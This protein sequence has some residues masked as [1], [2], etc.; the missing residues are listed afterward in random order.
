[1]SSVARQ[2]LALATRASLALGV[3]VWLGFSGCGKQTVLPVKEP[4]KC[5]LQV[6]TFSVIAS[7]QINP[8]ENGEPRPVQF[9]L[10]QLKNDV[11]FLNA[12]FDDVWKKDK[13]ILADDL[14]KVDE[15][16]A[17]PN[18]RT[19]VKFERDASAQYIVAAALF[20]TPKGRSWYTSYELP[21]PPSKGQCGVKGEDGGGPI[22]DPK[23]YAWIDRTKVEDGVEHAEDFPEGRVQSVQLPGGAPAAPAGA[24]GLPSMPGAPSLPGAPELPNAPSVPEVKA[25]EVP[26]PSLP[27]GMP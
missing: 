23:F 13:E 24:P 17:Y 10:Y 2:R 5:D 1:M 22:L 25:P 3:A 4:E 14:V 20:R 8:E 19:E 7:P 11:R 6:V 15:F 12:S 26:K 18:T 16:P 27:E 9:R 21:P